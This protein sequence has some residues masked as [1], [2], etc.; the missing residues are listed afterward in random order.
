MLELNGTLIAVIINFA[1]LAWLLNHFLYKPVGNM[2]AERKKMVEDTINSAETRLAEAEEVKKAYEKQIS[3]A[4]AESSD[5]IQKAG[6]V[7]EKMKSE[8][9]SNA[10]KDA[11]FIKVQAEKEAENIKTN[12]IASAKGELSSI[13]TAAASKLIKKSIDE[14]THR[15]LI[16]D[17]INKID[18]VNMN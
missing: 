17:M 13:I 11:E 14:N 9:I 1:I 18:R 4:Q 7:S 6:I 3:G 12:A 16:D 2:L 15:D 5:I 8:T 10:K